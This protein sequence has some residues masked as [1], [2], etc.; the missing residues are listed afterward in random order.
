MKEQFI[1]SINI[2]T[3][4][5]DHKKFYFCST[6][7]Q[8]CIAEVLNIS[9]NYFNELLNDIKESLNHNDCINISDFNLLNLQRGGSNTGSNTGSNSIIN[10]YYDDV[11]DNVN[12][13]ESI[14]QIIK[15]N[16]IGST[17]YLSSTY[18]QKFVDSSIKF[19]K[20]GIYLQNI[21]ISFD[22]KSRTTPINITHN[23]DGKSKSVNDDIVIDTVN[24]SIKHDTDHILYSQYFTK[25]LVDTSFYSKFMKN[26]IL[27]TFYKTKNN[28]LETENKKLATF[29][30]TK[31]NELAIENKKLQQKINNLENNIRKNTSKSE[32]LVSKDDSFINQ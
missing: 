12:D 8:Y 28:E 25:V 13:I 11:D 29:Y 2:T 31:N 10:N 1:R 9:S 27:A 16:N 5:Y 23:I 6:N 7:I 26:K 22:T 24:K 3:R 15:N 4:N 30:K 32:K 21:F 19:A 18:Y 17:F 14:N 20:H